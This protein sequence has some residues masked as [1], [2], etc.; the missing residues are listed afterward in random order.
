MD[1]NEFQMMKSL[2]KDDM[3]SHVQAL[4]D[5]LLTSWDCGLKKPLPEWNRPSAIV[6]SG[7]GGS[8]IAADLLAAY[9][10]P[11]CPIPVVIHRDYDLPAWAKNPDTLVICSSH[12]GNTEETLSAFDIAHAAGCKLLCISTGGILSEKAGYHDEMLWRFVHKGQPRAAI[13]LSFGL[14]LALVYRLGLIADPEAELKQAVEEMREQEKIIGVASP[15]VK[16]PAKRQ[17]GQLVGR[18]VA[19]FGSGLMA[20]VALRW[21]GQVSE[22]AKAWAQAETLPEADHN[23]V[24]GIFNP[25]EPLE[26]LINLFLQY[27]GDHPRNQLRGQATRQILMNEGLNTD[28]YTAKGSSALAQLW[29]AVHFGDYMAYYLAMCYG[30]DP[31]AIP[32]IMTLKEEMS[33]N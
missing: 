2:D 24:S 17:A 3:L 19:V 20:P 16:N 5:Q 7:M 33:E 25:S 30:T 12:S 23:T 27:P 18:M 11:I 31:T 22:V 6:V 4:P 9:L 32:S 8:A 21:K 14:L 1:L 26:H 28:V 10:R 15:V 29:T 13:G